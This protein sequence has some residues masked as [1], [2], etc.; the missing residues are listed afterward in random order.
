MGSSALS[1]KD[2]LSVWK[3]YNSGLIFDTFIKNNDDL[4]RIYKTRGMEETLETLKQY[5]EIDGFSYL[6]NSLWLISAG[7][8]YMTM[9]AKKCLFPFLWKYLLIYFIG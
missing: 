3:F 4:V 7:K 6:G 8:K 2:F 5:S 1:F 9:Q